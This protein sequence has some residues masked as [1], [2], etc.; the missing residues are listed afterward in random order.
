MEVIAMN[1]QSHQRRF[2]GLYV[3]AVICLAI[4]GTAQRALAGGDPV[5]SFPMPPMAQLGPQP[6]PV[7]AKAYAQ[8]VQV[9]RDGKFGKIADALAAI[10]DASASKRYAILVAAGTYPESQLQMKPFVDL[11]GGFASGDWKARDVYQNATII[12]G[13]KKG[14]IVIGSDNARLDGFTI[15][16]AERDGIGAA[17]FCDGVSPTIVNNV[18]VGNHTVKPKSLT[19]GLGK[20]IANE[21]AGIA[22]LNGSK[23]YVANNLICDN[24]TDAG[25]GAGITVRTNAHAKILR[26][27]FC[28][29]TAGAKDNTMFHGKE[30]SRSSPGAAIAVNDHS[31][32]QISYNVMV[33]GNALYRNDAG[34]IWVEGNSAP[35]ISYNMIAGN[36]AYDDG[37]GIYVMGDLF[38][39]ETG[40]RH[41]SSPDL[42]VRI[43]DNLVAGN[44]TV[45][46]GPGGLRVSRWGRVDL[47]RNRIVANPT[48]GAWGGEGGMI[49]VAEDN[50][51]TDNDAK[52]TPKFRFTSDASSRKFD[53]RQF[54]TEFA[55]SSDPGKGDL[56]G[57]A[58]RIGKQWSIV[59]SSG[60]RSVVVW[61][62]IDDETPKIEVLESY[63]QN[64]NQSVEN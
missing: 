3:A 27:V 33:L 54:V 1:F 52:K 34:G 15:T 4:C 38:Y 9:A 24:V 29:N 25:A 21:G 30:G 2:G 48:N 64:R 60:P 37:G 39:D 14:P 59:K 35:L 28:N 6:R 12:D 47:R 11:Y 45:Y 8:I 41:D 58:V 22:L 32:P 43:E 61:G 50:V 19:E 5:A 18:I 7:D 31:S 20:Q 57:S 55:T 10:K 62:R 36:T 44:N 26:N 63:L 53:Q 17:I 51:I 23:A 16:N 40:E 49:V 13:Q 46:G 42:S 56:G